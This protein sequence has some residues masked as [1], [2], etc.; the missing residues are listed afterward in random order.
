[1]FN[2]SEMI[3]TS[4]NQVVDVS[5]HTHVAIDIHTQI[6]NQSRCF[7]LVHWGHQSGI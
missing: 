5:G 4:A 6:S 7:N 3:E 1:M 2:P